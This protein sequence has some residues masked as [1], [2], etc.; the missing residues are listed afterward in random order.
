M[1]RD[2]IWFNGEKKHC[3]RFPAL[4]VKKGPISN[5]ILIGS[6][7]VKQMEWCWHC[8]SAC[9]A[10][11]FLDLLFRSRME[12][13][14][15]I[16]PWEPVNILLCWLEYI[17]KLASDTTRTALAQ[18]WRFEFEAKHVSKVRFLRSTARK[19]AIY[20]NS[21]IKLMNDLICIVHLSCLWTK[22]GISQQ[23][24]VWQCMLHTFFI[25]IKMNENH[26]LWL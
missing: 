23:I 13:H 17:N 26:M 4:S 19:C 24:M 22:R 7:F 20:C 11:F 15:N 18:I 6:S 14:C 8:K 3:K 12:M 10:W 16:T 5:V 1:L 9:S 25:L 21:S 2:V